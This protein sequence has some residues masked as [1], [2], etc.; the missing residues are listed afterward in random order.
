MRILGCTRGAKHS[1][2]DLA[3]NSYSL[4][5]IISYKEWGSLR[6]PYSLFSRNN[7]ALHAVSS[8]PH[9]KGSSNSRALFRS[10][11]LGVH[12]QYPLRAHDQFNQLMWQLVIFLT[13]SVDVLLK[14][15]TDICVW[16]CA[17][18]VPERVREKECVHIPTCVYVFVYRNHKRVL[19]VYNQN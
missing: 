6:S 16:M 9:W 4:A 18:E 19:T 7:Y 12:V 13:A 10:N 3:K 17:R 8:I 11:N 14:G 2:F 5:C 15:D 1:L